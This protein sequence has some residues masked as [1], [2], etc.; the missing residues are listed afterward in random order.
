[1]FWHIGVTDVLALGIY[2]LNHGEIGKAFG[3]DY[4]TV[5]Q[6]RRR[7]GLRLREDCNLLESFKRV[8]EKLIN[9]SNQ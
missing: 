2:L 3:V 1:M 4:S 6:N 5:S 8:S 7:L 9:L